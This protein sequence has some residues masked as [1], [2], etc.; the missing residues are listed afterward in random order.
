MANVYKTNFVV[1]G[2]PS[3]TTDQIVLENPS[4]STKLARVYI[5]LS[6]VADQSFTIWTLRRRDALPTHGIEGNAPTEQVLYKMDSASPTPA[7][8]VYTGA[9]GTALT[10]G[11]TV[12]W[13]DTVSLD[14][15]D[16]G[17]AMERIPAKYLPDDHALVVRPGECLSIEVPEGVV[18]YTIIMLLEE[19]TVA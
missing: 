12:T 9:P 6:V 14:A 10:F 5:P 4:D 1:T 7:C 19:K 13:L 3:G 18:D 16:A 17:D 2:A 11:G 15:S 8:K